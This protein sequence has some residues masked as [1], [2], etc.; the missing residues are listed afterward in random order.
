MKAFWVHLQNFLNNVDRLTKSKFKKQVTE[1]AI[2]RCFNKFPFL[3]ASKSSFQNYM[4]I[5][6]VNIH[7]TLLNK[8][9][10]WPLKGFSY[11]LKNVV[12]VSSKYFKNATRS[13]CF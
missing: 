11:F 7:V 1:A 5:C 12:I 8:E 10:P 2:K 6:F 3:K 4:H 13:G 9:F